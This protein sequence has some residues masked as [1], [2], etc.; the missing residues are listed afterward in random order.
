MSW[1]FLEPRDF[2]WA[3]AALSSSAAL[4]SAKSTV[5]IVEKAAIIVN[6]ILRAL[7]IENGKLFFFLSRFA[8]R[9][10]AETSLESR[11]N[12]FVLS[13][14]KYILP[15][16]AE[17]SQHFPL[18]YISWTFFTV[19]V[20]NFFEFPRMAGSFPQVFRSFFTPMRL[21]SIKYQLATNVRTKPLT[22]ATLL[23]STF[24]ALNL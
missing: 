9:A 6:I 2:S 16:T 15:W 17:I 20:W 11:E 10:P 7:K 22:P 18:I 3:R 13:S 1:Q 24:F 5:L 14:F 4:Q 12:N 23:P 19:A 21:K 8:A